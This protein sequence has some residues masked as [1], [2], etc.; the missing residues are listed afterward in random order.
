MRVPDRADSFD[1]GQFAEYQRVWRE[2]MLT[3]GSTSNFKVDLSITHSGCREE[4]ILLLSI[5]VSISAIGQLGLTGRLPAQIRS[6]G[7]SPASKC[8]LPATVAFPLAFPLLFAPGAFR[9][10]Q[11]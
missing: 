3:A 11:W 9:A 5:P 10:R 4:G 7:T 2:A 8:V 1:Q 6:M